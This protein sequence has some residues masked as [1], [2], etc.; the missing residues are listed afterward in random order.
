MDLTDTAILVVEMSTFVLVGVTLTY[1][2][3]VTQQVVHEH[4]RARIRARVEYAERYRQR[5]LR[6]LNHQI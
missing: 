4:R 6:Q 2:V 3:D 5:Q 1:I